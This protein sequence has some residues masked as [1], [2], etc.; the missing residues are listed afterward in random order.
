MRE[1]SHPLSV[2]QPNKVLQRCEPY[3][4]AGFSHLVVGPRPDNRLQRMRG[5][6]CFRAAD[7]SCVSAPRPR[8]SLSGSRTSTADVEDVMFVAVSQISLNVSGAARSACRFPPSPFVA[9]LQV[10]QLTHERRIFR[11]PR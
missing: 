7:K 4:G 6:A 2:S 5:L 1:R 10:P 3:R 9:W 11:C 8:S